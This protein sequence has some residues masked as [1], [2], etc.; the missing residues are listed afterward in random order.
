MR[1][2][3]R[4][5]N[6]VGALVSA[7]KFFVRKNKDRTFRQKV[8]ALLHATPY[9]GPLHR[10]IDQLII[11]S[12]LVSVVCIVLETVPGIH[13]IFKDEFEVL[14]IATFSLFAVEYLARAYASCESPHYSHPVKGRLKYLVS[15]PAL[16][17]LVSILPYF[18]GLLL[19]QFMDTRFL[20]IFRL[21]RLLK[22][23]RYT[24]TLNTLLKAIQREKR[25]LFASAFM[26]LL[27][28]VLTASVGY[29]DIS[30]ITPLG[31][32]MTVIISLIGIGIFAIPAGL[33]ASAFTDQLR[34]DRET[35]ENEFRDV[36]A[37]GQISH[38]DRNA[39]NAEAERLHLTE[40]D[41]N[42]IMERV[43]HEMTVKGHLG[44]G[45]LNAQQ[46]L[47]K[48]RQEVSSLRSL[49]QSDGFQEAEALIHDT[50]RTTPSE[51]AVLEALRK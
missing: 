17:D 22:V 4:K 11:W 32:A 33:M 19:N 15:I 2:L 27:L 39:L 41:V 24:G 3:F 23:T 48:Y 25:V 35:F 40:Q 21:T 9:S 18:L 28:V 6:V 44:L 51:R 38:T 45:H 30:P 49:V 29:G 14:E 16:I 47:E 12:V 43:K 5:I 20:R 10:Y 7:I 31:R 37:R 42:R 26:M 50:D 13:A 34:I 36:L 8:Y 46:L 1:V